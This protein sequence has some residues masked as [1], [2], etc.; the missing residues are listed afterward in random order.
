MTKV[1]H[2][3]GEQDAVFLALADRLERAG[4][5]LTQNNEDSDLI[6]AIGANASPMT[7]IDI[8]IIPAK[9]SNPNAKLI[10][11]IH[12]ILVPQQVD[13]WVLKLCQIG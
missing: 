4:A 7:E 9:I 11:R 5:T 3:V 12:D 13:G 2:L 10:F 8:A 1:V 6:I